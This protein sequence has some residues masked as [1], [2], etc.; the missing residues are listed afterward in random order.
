MEKDDL[1]KKKYVLEGIFQ[2]FKTERTNTRIYDHSYFEEVVKNY[3]IK[4]VIENIK[5]CNA[6]KV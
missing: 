4:A 2:S 5:E 6:K 1:K 3:S